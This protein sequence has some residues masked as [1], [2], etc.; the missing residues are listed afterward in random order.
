MK[1]D[2]TVATAH[3]MLNTHGLR[4]TAV[5]LGRIAEARARG[6]S[7]ELH[8]WENVERAIGELRQAG[9]SPPG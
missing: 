7:A 6:D 2:R 5:A 1:T 8:R 9:A 3:K 4:A